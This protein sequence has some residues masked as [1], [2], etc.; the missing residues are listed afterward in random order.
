MNNPPPN[1]NRPFSRSWTNE[2]DWT[3]VV[4]TQNDGTLTAIR[5][6]PVPVF[7][8]VQ[9]PTEAET[10]LMNQAVDKVWAKAKSI[11][12]RRIRRESLAIGG[13]R[14]FP[15]FTYADIQSMAAVLRYPNIGVYSGS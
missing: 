15:G 8:A 11:R 7:S 9:W 3:F 2:H 14:T 1:A 10:T 5:Q 13:G 4:Q 6:G 12:W